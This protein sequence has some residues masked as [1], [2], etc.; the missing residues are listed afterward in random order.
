MT[1]NEFLP[2]AVQWSE[3]MLL[4]PQHFQQN[5]IHAQAMMQQRMAAIAG[6][7]G[8]GVV[9]VGCVSAKPVGERLLPPQATPNPAR[10]TH[11]ATAVTPGMRVASDDRRDDA[12]AQWITARIIDA[13][14]ESSCR[15]TAYICP[16]QR[17]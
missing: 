10:S 7:V 17:I 5:D 12:R 15:S 3:G 9:V 11:A 2:D 4:S 16:I 1:D 14:L 8:V 6:A 13:V